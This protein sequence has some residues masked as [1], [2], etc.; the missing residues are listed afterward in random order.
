MD[1][2]P[3]GTTGGGVNRAA[4]NLGIGG[5]DAKIL[6]SNISTLR[7]LTYIVQRADMRSLGSGI[8]PHVCR[9]DFSP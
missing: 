4:R 3:E 6:V 7:T 9:R 8:L 2:N 5:V 1:L